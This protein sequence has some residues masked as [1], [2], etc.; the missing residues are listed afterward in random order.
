M[1]YPLKISNFLQVLFIYIYQCNLL[2]SLLISD[3]CIQ[4]LP[5]QFIFSSFCKGLWVEN[6]LSL[7]LK[8]SVVFLSLLS[9]S[10]LSIIP[11]EGLGDLPNGGTQILKTHE[12]QLLFITPF[13]GCTYCSCSFVIKIAQDR[14]KR[15]SSW[16]SGCPDYQA[17]LTPLG[18]LCGSDS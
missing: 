10:S 18:F 6:L 1:F 11:S 15:S 12:F 16:L 14:T 5:P 7:N 4:I 3:S 17:S 9:P 2:I 13:S 8:M